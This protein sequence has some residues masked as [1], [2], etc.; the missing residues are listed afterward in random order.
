[1]PTNQELVNLYLETIVFQSKITI[2]TRKSFYNDFAVTFQK[3][4]LE[5]TTSD[6]RNYVVQKKES[7]KWVKPTTISQ[8]I[9]YMRTFFKFLI[10][11]KFIKA[12]NN[13][14]SALKKPL[15]RIEAE[16][17]VL[18]KKEIQKMI[19][20][21]EAPIIGIKNRLLFYIAM[22]TGLRASEICAIKKKNIDFTQKMIF[23]PKADV[24]GQ[25]REKLVPIISQ[26]TIELIEQFLIKYPNNTEYLFLN[27]RGGLLK[28]GSVYNATKEII[29]LAF[30]HEGSWRRAYGPHLLRHVFAT[31]WVETGGDQH[32]LRSVMG[33]C[34]FAQID[35]YVH[36]SPAHITKTSQRV[37][38]NFFK[39]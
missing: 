16:I 35:R 2:K 13:P 22:T 6:L 11:E 7:K 5:A 36:I 10:S 34:S 31:R 9:G 28:E 37:A 4:F 32:T 38:K 23:M 24:K 18:S 26:R 30:I 15:N 19:S 33:W 14:T 1:M 12:E 25:Y 29:E 20:T 17:P 21:A 27:K 3:S 39:F 8:Y